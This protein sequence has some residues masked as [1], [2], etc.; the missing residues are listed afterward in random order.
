MINGFIDGERLSYVTPRGRALAD[1]C[2]SQSKKRT[3]ANDVI[4]RLSKLVQG[5]EAPSA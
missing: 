4:D 5:F 3:S 1:E 2:L